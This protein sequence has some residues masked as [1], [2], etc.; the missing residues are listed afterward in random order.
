MCCPGWTSPDMLSYPLFQLISL[1]G[2]RGNA[3]ASRTKAHREVCCRVHE[4]HESGQ[5]QQPE[6]RRCARHCVLPHQLVRYE[7][8]SHITWVSMTHVLRNIT[9]LRHT[10]DAAGELPLALDAARSHD[11]VATVLARQTQGTRRSDAHPASR[12]PRQLATEN[13]DTNTACE[14]DPSPRA[15]TCSDSSNFSSGVLCY[16]VPLLAP[17]PGQDGSRA[18]QNK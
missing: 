6:Q 3:V 16:H 8:A 12:R 11:A 13:N 14:L 15:T 5:P 7:P 9:R 17:F 1:I 2:L 10:Q 4:C 18:S